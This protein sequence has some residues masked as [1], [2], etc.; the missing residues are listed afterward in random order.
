MSALSLAPVFKPEVVTPVFPPRD[1][2][3]DILVA[4]ANGYNL[5]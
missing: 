2:A 5:R 3:A 1:Q 4:T